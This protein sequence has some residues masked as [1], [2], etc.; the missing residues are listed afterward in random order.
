MSSSGDRTAAAA[1]SIAITPSDAND[2]PNP[3]RLIDIEADGDA[4]DVAFILIGD[5][6]ASVRTRKIDH[7]QEIWGRR[8]RR[9]LETGTTATGLIGYV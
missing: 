7:G 5:A 6:D 2:L 4:G 9:V 8:I 1:K 3:V